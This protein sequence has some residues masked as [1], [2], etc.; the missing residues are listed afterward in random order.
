MSS[1]HRNI[2][3]VRLHVAFVE[4]VSSLGT[5]A[6]RAS[7][8]AWKWVVSKFNRSCQQSQCNETI[9]I[10]GNYTRS[11]TTRSLLPIQTQGSQNFD[12]K[13]SVV[14][15]AEINIHGIGSRIERMVGVATAS[16]STADSLVYILEHSETTAAFTLSSPT[17]QRD[18]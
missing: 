12:S 16:A 13:V 6:N 3:K 15:E 2:I 9:L 1:G 18:I 4:L 14:S 10:Y 5:D 11:R 8:G 7:N 17:G